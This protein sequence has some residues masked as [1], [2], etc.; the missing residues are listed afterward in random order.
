MSLTPDES[1]F[2]QFLHLSEVRRA[3]DPRGF[4]PVW[5]ARADQRGLRDRQDRRVEALRIL[6]PPARASLPFGDAVQSLRARDNYH[7]ENSHVI[8]ALIR[9]F[10]EAKIA[11]AESVT[12]WGSGTPRR[13]FLFADDL[14]EACIHLLSLDDPPSLVNVGAGS[15][16]TIRELAGL[17]AGRLVSRGNPERSDEAR[18]NSPETDGFHPDQRTRVEPGHRTRGRTSRCL[19]GFPRPGTAR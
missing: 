5:S 14:A 6:P 18:R 9:R 16:V 1:C 11:G 3:T 2:S 19:R 7:P 15:D 17:V 13:E 10:H 12:I 8:P 4:P